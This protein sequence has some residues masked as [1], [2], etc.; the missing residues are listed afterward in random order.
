MPTST[1]TWV[2]KGRVG[3][4]AQRDH[5][6]LGRQDEVGAHRALDLV[7]LERHQV[8]LRVGQRLVS[9]AWSASSSAFACRSLCASFSKPSKHRKAPPSISSG[10]ISQGRRR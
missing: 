3:H 6:D 8:D 5:D 1:A 4:R 9:S 10:V 7:L 2:P